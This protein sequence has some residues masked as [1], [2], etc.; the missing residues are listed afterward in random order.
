MMRRRTFVSVILALGASACATGRGTGDVA[1]FDLGGD[2]P[3][4]AGRRL[5]GSYALDEV[6]AGGALLSQAILYRLAYRDPAQLHA[7]ALSRWTESPAALM[8]RRLRAALSAPAE[9]GLV[10]VSDG[11]PTDHVVKVSLE[12]FEQWVD[13][14]TSS[15]AV[16]EARALLIDGTS[17]AFRGQRLFRAEEKC[18]SVDA[19]GAVRA[20]RI[21]ADRTIVD[22]VDWLAA[23]GRKPA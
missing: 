19:Q 10:M 23:T 13:S 7:Y 4:I 17:R 22:L 3:S 20:L 6:V 14:A 15:R 8:T 18:P 12:A 11:V 9:R 1:S 16:I 21:A 2:A 5:A